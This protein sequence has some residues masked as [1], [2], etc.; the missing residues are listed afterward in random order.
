MRVTKLEHLAEREG[1]HVEMI[2]LSGLEALE[3]ASTMSFERQR[4]ADAKHI[5]ELADMIRHGEWVGSSMIVMARN[6]DGKLRL[7]DGQ[8]RLRALYDAGVEEMPFVVQLIDGDAAEAYARLDAKQKVRSGSVVADALG[9]GSRFSSQ[10][11]RALFS[12]VSWAM[13]FEGTH[14]GKA[15]VNLRHP[16]D[17]KAV[18]NRTVRPSIPHRDLR[19]WI[20]DEPAL[21]IY[22]NIVSGAD[23]LYT[24]TKRSMLSGRCGAVVVLTLKGSP[25]LATEFWADTVRSGA[26]GIPEW[27]RTKLGEGIPSAV[28]RAHSYKGRIATGGWNAFVQDRSPKAVPVDGAKIVGTAPAATYA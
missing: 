22:N 13:T 9:Y 12:V 14:P 28:A 10:V 21:D 17:P 23:N 16:N 19:A 27:M 20:D 8:H 15:Q 25:D 18:K 5:A 2:S 26:S 3:I 7:V 4:H 1:G 6:G 24:K 11:T